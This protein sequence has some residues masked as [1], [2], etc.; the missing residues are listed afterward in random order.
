MIPSVR[1]LLPPPY[2]AAYIVILLRKIRTSKKF[3]LQ[4][5]VKC[6]NL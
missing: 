3:A 1:F 2:I 4:L 6:G 5:F